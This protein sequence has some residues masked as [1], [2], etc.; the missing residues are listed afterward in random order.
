LEPR[1]RWP[2]FCLPTSQKLKDGTIRGSVGRVTGKSNGLIAGYTIFP[3]GMVE[4]AS[5]VRAYL[6]IHLRL[7]LNPTG[8][9]VLAALTHP[10]VWLLE[11]LRLWR[12][13]E[14]H[15]PAND[16]VDHGET[17]DLYHE[18]NATYWCLLPPC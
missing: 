4:K 11:S 8:G 1:V 3:H 6:M 13:S 7:D 5:F 16:H 14:R 10:I 12:V 15:T 9:P 17:A 18:R 2:I